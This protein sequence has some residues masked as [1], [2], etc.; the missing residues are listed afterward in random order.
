MKRILAAAG[1]LVLLALSGFG[2]AR[3][4]GAGETTGTATFTN[5]VTYT[6]PTITQTVTVTATSPGTT[7]APTTTTSPS[8]P[9][10]SSQA[11]CGDYE[12]GNFTQWTGTNNS[13][14]AV[15][16]SRFG[17]AFYTCANVGDSNAQIVSIPVVQ[18]SKAAKFTVYSNNNGANG[19]STS[20]RAEVYTNVANTGGSPGEEHYY[21]WWSMLPASDAGRF[22]TN[23]S[24]WNL[25]TQF[26]GPGSTS[27]EVVV[28]VDATSSASTPALYFKVDSGTL[29][30]RIANPIQWGHWYHFVLHV[31]WSTSSSAGFVQ[32]FVDGNQVVPQTAQQTLYN[33][34][35]ASAYWKQGLYGANTG[36]ATGNTVYHDGACRADSFSA[37]ASC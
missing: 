26:H 31:K 33:V 35:G 11:F 2:L 12:T 24:D 13:T 27:G 17:D 14:G 22:V 28:G 20:P 9:T 18:G 23:T 15:Q 3:A 16:A 30:Q 21:G 1:L 36:D 29:K 32:L 6:I 25:I 10:C 7:T 4:V 37:A 8:A 34:S 5:V 19:C